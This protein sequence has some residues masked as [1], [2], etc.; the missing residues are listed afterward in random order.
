MKT[1]FYLIALSL[2]MVAFTGCGPDLIIEDEYNLEWPDDGGEKKI[3]ITVSN[4]GTKD[5]GEFLVYIDLDEDPV[6]S[7]HRPQA[8]RK[9]ENLSPGES[10]EI[11][12]NLSPLAHPDNSNLANV[13]R[14]TVTADPK[15][16]VVELDETNNKLVIDIP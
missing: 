14:I 4:I 6:S 15:S 8:T 2:F 3:T 7:N 5:S 1:A 11:N 16:M 13:Y 9:I 12:E 10:L